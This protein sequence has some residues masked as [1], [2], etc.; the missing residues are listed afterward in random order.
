MPVCMECK[1]SGNHSKGEFQN[2]KL[3]PLTKAYNDGLNSI[4][5]PSAILNGRISKLKGDLQTA[6][7]R[8]NTLNENTRAV[9]AE[10]NRLAQ[11]AITQLRLLSGRKATTIKSVKAELQRKLDEV[12]KYEEN[13]QFHKTNSDPVT[14][15][16]ALTLSLIHI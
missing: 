16:N 15:L 6:T 10:I 11:E 14:F 8:L 4:K 7:T 9:E 13:I 2:H 5:K 1:I 3:I 12:E